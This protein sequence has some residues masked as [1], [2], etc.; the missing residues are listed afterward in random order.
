MMTMTQTAA[1]PQPATAFSFAEYAQIIEAYRPLVRDFADAPDADSFCLVRHDIEFSLPRALRMAEIDRALGIRSTFFAQ[2]KNG[3]YN[4]LAPLNR[5]ILRKIH[6]L[7]HHVG[8]HFYVTDIKPG[9]EAETLRQLEFQTKVLEET[10]GQPVTRFSYHRP[11]LWALKL[12]L[13][14]K[15]PLINA[16]APR[17]FELTASGETPK[18]IKYMADSQHAWKYGHPLDFRDKYD[19]FQL[20]LHP[21]EWSDNGSDA[22]QNFHELI[23][24]NRD[25]FIRTLRTE[26]NHYTPLFPE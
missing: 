13:D 17:F 5:D 14:G 3:A 18:S 21:D 2:V 11:P 8:L 7:S 12:D 16:Y 9:D 25:E 26:C 10:L 24:G 15:S 19:R 20:L 1:S 4:P 22:A 6:A 23:D